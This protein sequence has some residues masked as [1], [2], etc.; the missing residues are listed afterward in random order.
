MKRVLC[1]LFAIAL[2]AALG[3][4]GA[5]KQEPV[6]EPEALAMEHGTTTAAQ[7]ETTEEERTTTQRKHYDPPVPPETPPKF[8]A[9]PSYAVSDT[10]IYGVRT[11]YNEDETDWKTTLYY[12]PLSDITKQKEIP[13]PK[14]YEGATLWEPDI[15]GLTERDLFVRQWYDR[16]K[17][18]GEDG[19][20][21]Y[22]ETS[23]IHRVALD[24]FEATVLAAGD[25]CHTPWYN[26]GSDSLLFLTRKNNNFQIEAMRLNGGERTT[27]WSEE[28]ENSFPPEH[29][30]NTVDGMVAVEGISDWI[31]PQENGGELLVVDKD[32]RVVPTDRTKI[33]F[34]ADIANRPKNQMEQSLKDNNAIRAYATCG[35]WV[36]YVE[37]NTPR[38]EDERGRVYRN[39]YRMK[40]DGTE[41]TLLREKTQIDSLMALDSQL[42]CLADRPVPE[43]DERIDYYPVGFY[44]LDADGKVTETIAHGVD[45]NSFHF[46]E[47]LGHLMLYKRF[48]IYGNNSGL[49]I[50]IYDPATG[51]KF[52][53]GSEDS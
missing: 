33:D 10:H 43:D 45:Y 11:E 26:A 15:I 35:D 1:A 31:P 47:P 20:T 44:A 9:T 18:D 14:T 24:N 38:E 34:S 3:A 4:C 7:E 36:Y 17:A 12:A 2:M 48:G 8:I 29:W 28:L 52:S 22:I 19:D 50:C 21:S 37:N 5:K 51:A 32:N 27:I 41:K 42:F 16:K 53:L 39:F 13:L 25:Y 46:F 40:A 6:T 49:L 23:V 30:R